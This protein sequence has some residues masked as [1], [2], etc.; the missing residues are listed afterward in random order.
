V[1]VSFEHDIV[2]LF[3]QY[4]GQM[5]WRFDLTNYEHVKANHKAIYGQISGRDGNMPPPPL[6]PL[7]PAQVELFKS[8]VDA[9]C[10]R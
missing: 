10:P 8:W 5:M 3:D 6:T 7:T 9:G 2:P 4:R 1:T